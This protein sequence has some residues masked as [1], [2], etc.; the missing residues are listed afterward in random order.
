MLCDD[1]VDELPRIEGLDVEGEL[2]GL[3]L[4]Q[5]QDLVD[6]PEEVLPAALD[7][8]ERRLLVG[9][10]RTVHAR[11]ERIGEAEDGGHR[12]AQLMADVRQESRLRLAGPLERRIGLA[13]PRGQPPLIIEQRGQA[14]ARAVEV[15]RQASELVA[16]RHVDA[17][18]EVAGGDVGERVVPS[19]GPAG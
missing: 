2:A 9:V 4:R 16:V 14:L 5:V 12:R 3:D 6:Q 11:E 15:S 8:A 13:Q 17:L 7:P 10:E 19:S 18:V 1:G